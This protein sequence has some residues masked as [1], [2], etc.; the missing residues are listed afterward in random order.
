MLIVTLSYM[1]TLRARGTCQ[2]GRYTKIKAMHCVDTVDRV[3]FAT[4]AQKHTDT[5]LCTTLLVFNGFSIQEK[6]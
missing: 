2:D 1:C 6:L 3:V 4:F 5:F